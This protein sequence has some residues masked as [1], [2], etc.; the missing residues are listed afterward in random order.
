MLTGLAIACQAALID[1]FESYGVGKIRDGVTN[2]VWTAID[3]GT[4]FAVIASDDG[5]TATNQ[6]LQ[7]GWNGGGRGAYRGIDAIDDASTATLF[8]QIMATSSSQDTSFGLSDIAA[9]A[10][11]NWGDFEIQMAL[12]NGADAD[13]ADLHGRN[14][15]SLQIAL[16]QWYNVWV[17]VNQ[18]T[19]TWDMYV[20][21]GSADAAAGDLLQSGLS[22]RNGTVDDLVSFMV[23]TNYRDMNYKI[24]NIGLADGVDLSVVPEPATLALLGLGG[25]AL[26]RRKR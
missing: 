26:V 24:D 9:H 17:V 8:L 16:N 21:Q 14:G 23:L 20:N 11:A 22:F 13:H 19:D 2:G 6:Y 1:S 10:S 7:T 25:L 4:S 18:T 15:A 12:S 3:S 5:T